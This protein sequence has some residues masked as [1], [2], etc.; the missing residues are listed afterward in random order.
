VVFVSINYHRGLSLQVQPVAVF[1]SLWVAH[2]LRGLR[3]RSGSVAVS[4]V[5]RVA[6]CTLAGLAAAG[7]VGV[8]ATA[9]A[10][11]LARS[12]ASAPSANV[13]GLVALADLPAEAQHTHR[14]ILTGGPFPY[15][16]DGV[17]FGN[18][19]QRLPRQARGYYR[20]YTVPTPGA[21]NRGARRMVCGGL[22]VR[23][24]EACFYSSDHYA[25]F[26]QLA[27]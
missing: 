25:S 27:P 22:V 16:K 14:L 2:T 12:S 23:A 24:P 10:T 15:A 19:E 18:R 5:G 3:E 9:P 7:M 6:F 17:V 8:L 13:Q 21:S 20:E 11:A 1:G 26:R 4:V